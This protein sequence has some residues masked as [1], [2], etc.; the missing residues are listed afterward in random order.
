MVLTKAN[1]E[2]TDFK[3]DTYELTDDELDW[4][5]TIA[6]RM[7]CAITRHVDILPYNHELL[8][9]INKEAL[10]VFY[11]ASKSEPA[12]DCFIT[13]DTWFIHEKYDEAINNVVTI[14][15]ESLEEVI[16]HELAHT[17]KYR[18]CKYH[19]RLTHAIV[20]AYEKY[21]KTGETTTFDMLVKLIR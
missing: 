5:F 9:G 13:I 19:T 11:T 21:L 17:D 10:G 6:N 1:L 15:E 3:D 14:C 12:K 2:Y 18:H 20:D 16:A 4:F 7:Q 8:P